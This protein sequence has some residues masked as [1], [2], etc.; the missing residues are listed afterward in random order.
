MAGLTQCLDVLITMIFQVKV[1]SI[2]V[3]DS[4]PREQPVFVR[5]PLPTTFLTPELGLLEDD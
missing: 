2:L 5:M 3:M 4:K 1:P